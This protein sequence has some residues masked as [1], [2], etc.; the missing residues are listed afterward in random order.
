M[1]FTTAIST[2]VLGFAA[3][4]SAIT[5]SYDPGYDIKTRAMTAVT[6]SDGANG[7]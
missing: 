6:C 1:Q 7:L 4:S 3:L 2:A 5:V